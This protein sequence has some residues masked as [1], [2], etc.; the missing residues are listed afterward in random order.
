[1]DHLPIFINLRQKPCLVVGGGD[2]ALRK[3]N[4]LLKAQASITCISPVFCDGLNDLA[5]ENVLNLV[6]KNFEASD[7][8]D[9][10]VIISATNDSKVN[11][12]VSR[13]AHKLRIPVNVV[14]SP[15]LS[16]FIMPSIVDR[17]IW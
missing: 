10:S 6:K 5:K 1:M 3:I 9:H 8:S 14:D 12:E 16:S 11:A 13:L 7:I 4:L 2:I 17:S 15:D